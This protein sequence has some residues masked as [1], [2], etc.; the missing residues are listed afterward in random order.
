MLGPPQ[1]REYLARKIADAIF[2]HQAG[3]ELPTLRTFREALD[4]ARGKD[5]EEKDIGNLMLSLWH[6]L[7]PA[8]NTLSMP[9][10]TDPSRALR[11][12]ARRK[13]YPGR[14]GGL[15]L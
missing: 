2:A 14:I 7:P 1:R 5:V 15:G 11:A 6:D 13:A 9:M 12:D 10:Q 3:D 4:L 8:D